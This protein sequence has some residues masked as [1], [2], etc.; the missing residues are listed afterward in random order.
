MEPIL[1]MHKNGGG[2]LE[3]M[4]KDSTPVF[5]PIVLA[6]EMECGHGKYP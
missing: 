4:Q 5:P 3:F 1:S 2:C 6:L